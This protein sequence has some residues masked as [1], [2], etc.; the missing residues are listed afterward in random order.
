MF[1]RLK[2]DDKREKILSGYIPN[3]TLSPQGLLSMKNIEQ[4][5]IRNPFPEMSLE[6]GLDVS[7][8]PLEKAKKKLEPYGYKLDTELSSREN[9]VFYNPYSNKMVF[10]V[11]GTN[12]LSARDLATDAYLAFLGRAGLIQTSRFK[13]AETTLNKAR[14]KYKGSKKVLISHSLGSSITQNLAKEGEEIKGFGTGSGLYSQGGKGETYRTFYDPFSFTSKDKIIPSYIPKKKGNLRGQNV[15]D[16]PQGIFP[17][18]SYQNL[19]GNAI[20]V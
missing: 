13:E 5:Q 8:S 19:R 11:A 20:F 4:K 17:S 3:K 12:P 15:V 7:Y 14:Q 6:K 2:K 10:S 16:Y 18:H 9:K 1:G